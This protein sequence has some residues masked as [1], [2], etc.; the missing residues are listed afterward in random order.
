MGWG[1]IGDIVDAA[2]DAIEEGADWV[3]GAAEDAAEWVADTAEDIVDGIED[4]AEAVVDAV[5]DAVDAVVD[6]VEEALDDIAEAVEDALEALGDAAAD[7]WEAAEEVWDHVTDAAEDAWET[8]ADGVEQ[9]WT[10]VS[11]AVEDA[12]D[13]VAAAADDAWEAVSQAAEDA[14]DATVD[15]AEDAWERAEA[16]VM[17]GVNAMVAAYEWAIQAAG[18]AIEWLG[19]LLVD[20]GELFLQ[21]GA[22]LAG[23]VVYRVAKWGNIIGNI[24]RPPKLLPAGFRDDMVDVF[25]GGTAARVI[26]TADF[27]MVLYV[28]DALLS[29]NWFASGTDAMTFGATSYLGVTLGGLIY[30]D[31][32]WDPNDDADRQLM[33]HELVHTT[34]YRRFVNETGFACA[35][36]IGFAKAGFDY[37]T[38]PLED[39]AFTFERDNAA[40]I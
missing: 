12:W 2:G 1:I 9:L 20:I 36:G 38:N 24:Y 23:Q 18:D 3:A 32:P 35:Y 34:Q 17:A 33:A 37:R 13:A 26:N 8:I 15:A 29:A 6:T 11:D 22:C 28:D 10:T 16:V 19:G 30:L 7:V 14:W 25:D 31:E 5:E 39:E 40:L 4:A 21:L 27:A